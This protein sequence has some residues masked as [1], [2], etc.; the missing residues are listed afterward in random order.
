[1]NHKKLLKNAHRLA[2]RF[3]VTSD[4][5]RLKNVDPADTQ[6]LDDDALMFSNGVETNGRFQLPLYS[7]EL[8]L[9]PFLFSGLGYQR[10]TVTNSD[11]NS[12]IVKSETNA[13]VMP[14]GAGFSA[15]YKHF[16][17]EA[18]F[19]YRRMIDD[20]AI[21]APGAKDAVDLQNWAAGI[22]IGYEI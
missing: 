3:R 10:L 9:T 6:G 21:K 13:L 8:Q 18:R 14:M 22:T 4:R 15:T 20:D 7:G 1:M 5:F 12:S 16:I 2:K 17:G 11:Y 19:T